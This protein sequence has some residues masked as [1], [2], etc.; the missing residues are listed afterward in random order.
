MDLRRCGAGGPDRTRHLPRCVHRG[1]LRGPGALREGP[2]LRR[3]RVPVPQSADRSVPCGGGGAGRHRRG[4]LR[5]DRTGQGLG[6][7]HDGAAVRR[8]HLHPYDGH[9]AGAAARSRVDVAAGPGPPD[10]SLQRPG[11]RHPGGV[12]DGSDARDGRGGAGQPGGALRAGTG[13][14]RRE[15]GHTGDAGRGHLLPGGQCRGCAAE[16]GRRTCPAGRGRDLRRRGGVR[17]EHGGAGRATE[18]GRDAV[19]ADRVR[20]PSDVHR[21]RPPPRRRLPYLAVGPGAVAGARL[22]TLRTRRVPAGQPGR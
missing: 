2:G 12:A 20:H 5:V 6:G 3:L 18:G 15:H 22:R 8:P 21:F 4:A 19:A 11:Q 1:L 7:V 17:D 16:S 9:A 10:L 14:T 13:R